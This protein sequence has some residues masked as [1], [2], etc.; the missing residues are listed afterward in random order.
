MT[1]V[2]LLLL[3]VQQPATAP[4]PATTQPP[5]A[6]Q[7]RRVVPAA[8]TMDVRV[9]D[10][11]GV[12]AAGAH[13][14]AMGPT[15]RE[16]TTD[17]KGMVSF[18]T[19][20]PGTYRVHAEGD[21]FVPLEKE[22]VVRSGVPVTTEFSL[23]AAPRPPAPEPPHEAPPPPPP[24][25][26]PPA[27]VRGDPRVLSIPDLAE[28]SLN[29]KEPVKILPIGCTGLSLARLIVLREAIPPT[30]TA[31]ADET[32]YLVA[33]EATL[34]INGKEQALT[35]GWFSVVPRG[36]TAGVGRKG[37]NPAILLSTLYGRPCGAANSS[38]Q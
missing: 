24:P 15:T 31:D 23:S 9:I 1:I 10:R 34:T 36:T 5:A 12:P 20:T 3:A 14:V 18:K 19:V 13:V 37:R 16:G 30:A 6:T 32:L 28:R 27:G 25:P 33:G 8:V 29:G 7:P 26:P 2:L 21:G 11:S 22:I 35:P 17:A 4:P 38:Q